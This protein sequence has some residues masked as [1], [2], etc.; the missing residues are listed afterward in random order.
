[1]VSQGHLGRVEFGPPLTGQA[2]TLRVWVGDASRTP[3]VGCSPIILTYNYLMN[4]DHVNFYSDA[5][6][7]DLVMGA[8]A[9]EAPLKFYRRQVARY[10]KP[11]L[12]LACGSGRLTIPLANE[13]VNITGMDISVEML[14]LAKLKASA[15][16]L[17]IRFIQG[18]MRSFDLGEKFKFIFIPAQSLS[19]LH[20]RAEIEDCFACVLQHLASE[21][22]F[23]IELFNSSVRM[24][25]RETDRRYPVGQYVDPKA[26][27][28]VFVTEEVRYDAASQINHIRWFFRDERSNKETVLSFEMRQFFP[29]EIDALLGY[30]GFLIEHKYG[31]YDEGEFSSDALKQLIVCRAK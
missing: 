11:V 5:Q 10:G 26:G 27:S 15:S 25:A 22:R 20:T 6:C 1:M 19:H 24:L 17:S 18:D 4:D 31:S 28:Q 9:S 29:Q 7:Y 3:A 13:G 8:Y 14:N 23:L 21:G 12:E 2:S 16:G 30:N